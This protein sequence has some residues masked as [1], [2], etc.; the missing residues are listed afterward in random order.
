MPAGVLRRIYIYTAAF[1]GLQLAAQGARGV[2]GVVLHVLFE[3]PTIGGREATLLWLSES[4]ALLLVG[5]P[6][7]V[8]HWAAAQRHSRTPEEQ[9]AVLRRLYL[10]LALLV[11]LLSTLFSGRDLL[12]GLAAAARSAGVDRPLS[13]AAAAFV[14]GATLWIYH[15]RVARFDR[16]QVERAGPPATLRRWYLVLALAISLAVASGGAVALI[17]QL[18]HAALSSGIGADAALEVSLA[19]LVAG[20]AI[21]LPHQLWAR[22]L[23]ARPGPLQANE[24]ASPL[25]QVYT[26]LVIAVSEAAALAGIGLLVHALLL[27]LLGRMPWRPL[28]LEQRGALAVALVAVPL[29]AYHALLLA[30]EAQLSVVHSRSSTTAQ[31][32]RFLTMAVGLIALFVGL[33]GLSGVLLRLL[34]TP[35]VIGQTWHEP[36]SRFLA[37]ALVALP[38]YGAA[39]WRSERL[40]AATPSEQH[41]LARRIYLY[42]ALLF[43]VGAATVAAVP[44][45]QALLARTVGVTSVDLVEAVARWAGY[46]LWALPIVAYHVH[47]LRSIAAL[48][49]PGEGQ[50]TAEILRENLPAAH[51]P[52]A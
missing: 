28:M 35:D 21:W 5:L 46:L 50:G 7:W 10:Y 2:I 38:V 1:V 25:R 12:A 31:I 19:S 17:D 24:S 11:A 6:L 32:I 37:L 39:G 36:L 40:A 33:G 3:D 26:G 14:V 43:G 9:R 52:D 30:Q 16:A 47:K 51:I 18:L 20:A 29:W 44:L 13:A 34:L 27:A 4:L 23:V 41:S 49:R 8:V 42:G 15:W 22:R 48:S 45:L